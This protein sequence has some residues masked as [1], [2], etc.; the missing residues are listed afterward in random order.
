LVTRAQSNKAAKTGDLLG[1]VRDSVHNY[2]LQTA[3][4]A[5]YKKSDSTLINYQLTNNFGEFHFIK[6]PLDTVLVIKSSFLGY[7][8]A[9]HDFLIPSSKGSLDLKNINLGR[10][11]NTLHEVIIKATSPPVRM[12][13][14]TLEFNA[15]AF[16]LDTN[17]VVEDLLKK[18]PGVEVW[19]DGVI[20]INGKTVSKVL[21][22]GKE[23]FGGNTKTAIENLPKNSVSKIQVYNENKADLLNTRTDLN[24]VLK[25]NKKDGLFGKVEGGYGSDKK[26]DNNGMVNYFDPENQFSIAGSLN[27][28]NK[29]AGSVSDLFSYTSYKGEGVGNAYA[30]DFDKKGINNFKSIGF[31]AE[32]SPD[33]SQSLKVNYFRND[34]QSTLAQNTLTTSSLTENSVIKQ[35]SDNITNQSG[36]NQNGSINFTSAT[37]YSD[38]Y[39]EGNF[40]TTDQN[41]NDKVAEVTSNSGSGGTAH[42]LSS[43]KSNYTEN[44]TILKAGYHSDVYA[45]LNHQPLLAFNLDYAF[46]AFNDANGSTRTSE[47]R[48]EQQNLIN[49]FNRKYNDQ[50]NRKKHTLSFSKDNILGAGLSTIL[51]VSVLNNLEIN[52]N[53][54]S[55][56]T[57]DFNNVLGVYLKNDTL[58]YLGKYEIVDERPALRLKKSFIRSLSNRFSKILTIE[59]T[60]RAQYYSQKNSS[61]LNFQN[62]NRNYTEFIPSSSISYRDQKMQKYDNIYSLSYNAGLTYPDIDQLVPIVDPANGFYLN[63][64]N[65]RLRPSHKQEF[66]FDFSHTNNNA[67][68][69]IYNVSVKVGKVK[70]YLADSTLYDNLGRVIHYTVNVNQQKYG[71]V[72]T[73]LLKS[74]KLQ[75]NL[76]QFS[77]RGGI[78]FF[79]NPIYINN[80]YLLAKTILSNNSLDVNYI[81]NSILSLRLTQSFQTF[82]SSQEN[83]LTKTDLKNVTTITGLAV[84]LTWPKHFS[85]NSNINF[86]KNVSP[87]MQPIDFNIWNAS[88]FYRFFKGENA[89]VKLSALDL[90]HQNTGLINYGNYNS[91]TRGTAAVLR[92]Y[93]MITLSYYPRKFGLKNLH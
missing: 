26:Y 32:H 86:S 14:D 89:E 3:T 60:G 67:M 55:Y 8:T 49:S 44:Q 16:K 80:N 43:N 17:A 28:V 40:N 41:K 38:Y 83:N 19:G 59:F 53:H 48:D 66:S 15:Q 88:M 51:N 46:T 36:Y 33:K 70:D 52:Q 25:K 10:L 87:G 18:L 74:Y 79:Q 71:T 84:N 54:K 24:I 7:K 65:I 85:F 37:A 78:D 42:Y 30:S 72:A 64:G 39:L 75:S 56:Q 45:R 4:V 77:Y 50:N 9:S 63:V 81:Y 82:K 20:T 93:F 92:Q 11:E 1:V 6:L 61:T 13:G 23:F 68:P 12:N 57:N 91:I 22:E 35:T 5:I 76:I 69:F 21:V 62:F 27:N 90:L 73:N 58:S 29:T 47:T 34:L 31:A 2:A